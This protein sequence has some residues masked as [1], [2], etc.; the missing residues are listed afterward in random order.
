MGFRRLATTCIPA[1][2][3]RLHKGEK[4]MKHAK[5]AANWYA[6]VG[7]TLAHASI[8]DDG[9]IL[10]VCVTEDTQ[11]QIVRELGDNVRE[12]ARSDNGKCVAIIVTLDSWLQCFGVVEGLLELG[13]RDCRELDAHTI[14]LFAGEQ[15]QRLTERQ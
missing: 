5:T 2:P 13:W 8:Y 3:T 7:E 12:F 1:L 6:M 10:Y 11:A 14:E 15:L 4:A 9:V